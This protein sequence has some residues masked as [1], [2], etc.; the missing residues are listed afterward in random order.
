MS[1][2]GPARPPIVPCSRSHS[3][4][5]RL[6][7]GGAATVSSIGSFGVIVSSTNLFGALGTQCFS[8]LAFTTAWP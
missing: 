3:L 4:M 2:S 6:L 7:A 5:R 8:V 1:R